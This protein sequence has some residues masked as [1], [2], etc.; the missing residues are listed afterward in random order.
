MTA[1]RRYLRDDRRL[2]RAQVDMV[3]YWRRE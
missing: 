1:V 3:A 2:T